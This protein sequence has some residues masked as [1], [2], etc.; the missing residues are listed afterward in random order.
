M[1][2]RR[3]GENEVGTNYNKLNI[4]VGMQRN[5][6]SYPAPFLPIPISYILSKEKMQYA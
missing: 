6:L 5:N 3:E 2:S 1:L 4:A